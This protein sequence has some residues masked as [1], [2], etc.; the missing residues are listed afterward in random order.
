MVFD[1]LDLDCIIVDVLVE[2]EIVVVVNVLL[3]VLGCYLNFGLEVLV[4]NGV[5]LID[6]IGL[7]IFKKVKDGV[8]VCLYEGGVY[9]GD[10]WL[11]CGIECMDYDIVDLMWEVKSGLVVYLE[12]FVGNIIEFICSESLLLIDGIGI[13]DVDVDLWCW[14]VVIVV[15]E[16]SGFDDLKFF[17]LFI[18]EY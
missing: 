16:F 7:E 17:K 8:K 2:V 9:V 1:V 18:K 3:F 10:C 4:I 11:I 12:V 15:D 14:Y 5:M 13:F 6:E